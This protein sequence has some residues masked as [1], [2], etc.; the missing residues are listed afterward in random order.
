MMRF[1]EV[2]WKA[3]KD[4]AVSSISDSRITRDL[5]HHWPATEQRP[6]SHY[7]PPCE[8]RS[9]CLS[10]ATSTSPPPVVVVVPGQSPRANKNKQPCTTA[11]APLSTAAQPASWYHVRA[12][13]KASRP[14]S[15]SG[16]SDPPGRDKGPRRSR[17]AQ[18][19]AARPNT[20]A[21]QPRPYTLR[22]PGSSS[23]ASARRRVAEACGKYDTAMKAV[24]TGLTR[25]VVGYDPVRRLFRQQIEDS[26]RGKGR[27]GSLVLFL[28][29]PGMRKCDVMPWKQ[30]RS[31]ETPPLE[32]LT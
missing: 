27:A 10:G 15:N 8:S 12:S 2:V 23:P 21:W 29:R 32:I 14:Q 18:A 5:S 4:V 25:T 19:R 26:R 16:W 30:P 20:T 22:A 13:P 31:G 1:H 6:A 9:G 3:L 17:N 7:S 24:M 28:G 11:Y